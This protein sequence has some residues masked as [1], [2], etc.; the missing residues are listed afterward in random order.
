MKKKVRYQKITNAVEKY[1]V[2]ILDVARYLWVPSETV[3]KC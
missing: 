1:R 3:R 2:L